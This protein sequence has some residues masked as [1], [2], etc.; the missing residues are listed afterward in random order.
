MRVRNQR[1]WGNGILPWDSSPVL[2][3]NGE[4]GT[5][6]WEGMAE[7]IGSQLM[8][9]SRSI[10]GSSVSWFCI[11]TEEEEESETSTLGF[12]SLIN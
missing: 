7:Q 1:K 3:M 11:I 8:D 12:H 4:V 5:G 6:H 2:L 10:L 9:G